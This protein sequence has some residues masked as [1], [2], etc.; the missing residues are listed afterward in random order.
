MECVSS[1]PDLPVQWL[2]LLNTDSQPLSLEHTLTLNV[3]PQG[4]FEDGESFYCVTLDPESSDAAFV[5]SARMVVK[6]IEGESL[7]P[8]NCVF[9]YFG[10][11]I[12]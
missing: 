4:G 3:P 11:V 1:N 12:N 10:A 2:S 8:I 5:A 7:P 6:N 9:S